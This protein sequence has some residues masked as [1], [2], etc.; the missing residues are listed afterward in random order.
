[1]LGVDEVM[2]KKEIDECQNKIEEYK[3][4]RDNTN[5]ANQDGQKDIVL[6]N[7]KMENLRMDANRIEVS[8]DDVNNEV[9]SLLKDKNGLEGDIEELNNKRRELEDQFR[10][11]EE[12]QM[13]IERDLNNGDR[14]LKIAT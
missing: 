13:L 8:A 5:K 2:L 4:N 7:E 9:T 14:N 3:K 1:M 6:I 11:E 10:D 12:K